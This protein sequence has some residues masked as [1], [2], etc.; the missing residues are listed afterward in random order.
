MMTLTS[1]RA[2]TQE[3]DNVDVLAHL[4]DSFHHFQL[5]HKV[6]LVRWQ[7]ILCL[8]WPKLALVII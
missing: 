7:S 1:L 6:L 4:L 2:A 8:K 5:L 3:V